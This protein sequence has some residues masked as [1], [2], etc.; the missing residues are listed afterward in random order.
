MLVLDYAVDDHSA[1][2]V[3]AFLGRT[4]ELLSH[5]RSFDELR[6]V[7]A[8]CPALVGLDE[9]RLSRSGAHGPSDTRDADGS[10]SPAWGGLVGG[11]DICCLIRGGPMTVLSSLDAAGRPRSPATLPGYHAGRPPRK[12]DAL[13]G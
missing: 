4:P 7:A 12:G 6:A 2:T 5:V 3:V 9:L 8:L 13:P 10:V 1:A 11:A